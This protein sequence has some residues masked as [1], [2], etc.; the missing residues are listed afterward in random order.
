MPPAF[1]G[2]GEFLP[3][4][5]SEGKTLQ[6][7]V[8]RFEAQGHG[9]E[10]IKPT[11][12]MDAGISAEDNLDWLTEQGYPWI[13]VAKG[14]QAVHKP[15]QGAPDL[16]HTT[17]A[18]HTVRVWRLDSDATETRLYVMSEG[19]RQTARSIRERQVVK[20]EQGLQRLHDN[21]S[22]PRRMKQYQRV[23]EAV[24]RLKERHPGIARY[25]EVK[26]HRGDGDK[27]KAVT[28][29]RKDS[30][31]ESDKQLGAVIYAHQSHRLGS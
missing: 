29:T 16:T 18:D 19:R 31:D 21:L 5:I 4:N 14:R 25:Y 20:F 9:A 11:V 12:V 27:A 6:D 23:V 10:G 26:V 30:F 3:G 8:R 2:R 17:Q 22:L 15:P 7:A 1:P 24:G 28:F 13:C